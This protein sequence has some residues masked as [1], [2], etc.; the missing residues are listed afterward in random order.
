MKVQSTKQKKKFYIKNME[1]CF[2]KFNNPLKRT[3]SG[4]TMTVLFIIIIKMGPLP[5]F[6]CNLLFITKSFDELIKIGL[7]TYLFK[8]IGHIS[9]FN[10]FLFLISAYGFVGQS[11]F[12]QFGQ[13]LKNHRFLK[14]IIKYHGIF[15]F[16]CYILGLTFFLTGLN[17]KNYFKMYSMI[18][19][20]HVCIG[21]LIIPF[22]LS[23]KYFSKGLIW[24]LLPL[25]TV[26]FN[27]VAA[28]IIGNVCGRH[29]LIEVS[30]KKTWEGFLGALILSPIFSYSLSTFMCNFNYFLCPVKYNF[31][32]TKFV[33]DQ[34]QKDQIFYPRDYKIAENLKIS[35]EPFQFH[36][37]L[38]S[39]L[40][41]TFGPIGGFIASGFKRAYCIKDF[42]DTIP[43]HG[44]VLD[45]LDCQFLFQVFVYFYVNNIIDESFLNVN[46]PNAFDVIKKENSVIFKLEN[47]T[48]KNL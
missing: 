43:G 2:S 32:Q 12:D 30:P 20:V 34:C 22:A 40:A 6:L 35:I 45:R 10:W 23:I 41:S 8:P 24:F 37:F 21:I 14:P 5:I 7:K 11:I 17:K 33:I 18:G 4:I 31:N 42:G 13:D 36:A 44:G 29:K 25:M 28:Y 38:L 16:S 26:I 1:S 15:S 46:Y 39:I 19:Y 3:I 48:E 9:K 27:D 47:L